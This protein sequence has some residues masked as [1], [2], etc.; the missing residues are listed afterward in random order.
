[1]L[2][3][4]INYLPLLAFLS[5]FLFLTTFFLC[6][7]FPFPLMYSYVINI[8]N[9][10]RTGIQ[11]DQIIILSPN[12]NSFT[13]HYFQKRLKPTYPLCQPVCEASRR[14]RGGRI[15][16]RVDATEHAPVPNHVF[17]FLSCSNTKKIFY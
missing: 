14:R 7:I 9:T 3:G 6:C 8:I 15:L 12:I 10:N 1:M 2:I 5:Y 4:F 11:T 17:L 16:T 13:N